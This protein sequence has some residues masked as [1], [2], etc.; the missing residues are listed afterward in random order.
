MTE[1]EMKKA[2]LCL[3]RKVYCKEYIGT[4]RLWKI[5]PNGWVVRLGMNNDDKPIVISAEL[6]DEKFLRYFEQELR[7]RNWDCSKWFIG[8]KSYPYHPTDPSCKQKK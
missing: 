8:V 2:I 1:D 7:D 4:L 6:P 3:I 5:N